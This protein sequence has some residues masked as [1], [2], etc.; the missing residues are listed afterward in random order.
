M[1]IK[2]VLFLESIWNVGVFHQ[3]A[4]KKLSGKQF[5]VNILK[6][7]TLVACQK[8]LTNRADQDLT[9]PEEAF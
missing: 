9:A 2:E 7:G 4:L 3:R 1:T 6:F 8:A 5:T